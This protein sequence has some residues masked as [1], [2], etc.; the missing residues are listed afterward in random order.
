MRE[1]IGVHESGVD[2]VS[3]QYITIVNYYH[4]NKSCMNK[5]KNAERE[6]EERERERGDEMR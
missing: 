2:Y 4:S 5:V 3:L 1:I 6:E